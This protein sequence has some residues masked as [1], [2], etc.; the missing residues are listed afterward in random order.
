[1]NSKETLQYQ[2]PHAL[3]EKEKQFRAS[4]PEREKQLHDLATKML[5]SSYFT[6]KTH[7]YTAWIKSKEKK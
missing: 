4:L 3:N 5:G 1:M 6:G 7:G 2:P